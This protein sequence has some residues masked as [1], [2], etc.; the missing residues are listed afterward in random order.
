MSG[1]SSSSGP[2][3]IIAPERLCP[4][5]VLAFSITAT[6]TSPSFSISSASSPS[7]WSSRLA[8][9]SPAVPPPTIAT[10]TS[11]RSSSE[12]SSRLTNSLT[13]STG[14]G[15]SLGACAPFRD[16]IY[17]PFLALIASASF[18]RI[19]FRSPTMPRSE[20]SKIGAFDVDV[21]AT[22]LAALHHRRLRRPRRELDVDVD[23]L[24]RAA[25]TPDGLERVD[26]AD[27]DPEL[28][29][30][31]GHRDLRVL[32]DG[33][34]GDELAVLGSDRGD[35]HRHAGML[36]GGEPGADL[37]AEEAATEQRVGVTVLVDHLRHPVDDRL[38]QP[39]RR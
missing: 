7:S 25:V 30:V 29:P 8:H 1:N 18:G 17:E 31:A 24:G 36:A 3:R 14:G 28:T 27:D 11:I 9:A 15:Y 12:S 26:P 4:P 35:L 13:E 33:P 39:L 21:R 23:N 32:Q 19:L 38:R 37:E 2:G 34:L 6:G 16:D 22:L 20:N 5:Q 10:P